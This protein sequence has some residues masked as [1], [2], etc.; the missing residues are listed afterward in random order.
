M[1]ETT[2]E[3]V[4]DIHSQVTSASGASTKTVNELVKDIR[5]E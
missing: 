2:N 1:N 5:D 4:R 3:V